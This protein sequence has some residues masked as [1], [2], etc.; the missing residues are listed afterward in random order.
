MTYT[1]DAEKDYERLIKRGKLA[2]LYKNGEKKVIC[3]GHRELEDLR[4]QEDQ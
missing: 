1:S 2:I 4:F 3:T